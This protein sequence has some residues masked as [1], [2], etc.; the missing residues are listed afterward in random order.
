M[1]P[2]FVLFPGIHMSEIAWEYVFDMN[3]IKAKK[4]DFITQ[5][6]KLGKV[7][8]FTPKFFNIWYYLQFPVD[9]E[10]WK[11]IYNKYKRFSSDID[12][13][14]ED[15]NYDIICK[16]IHTDVRNKYG[17]TVKLIPIGHSYGSE[18]ALLFSKMYKKECLFSVL[19][20]GTVHSLKLQK[21][22]YKEYDKKNEKMVKKYFNNNQNLHK[23]LNKI[24][25]SLET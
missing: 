14:L 10:K 21:Q 24:K 5:L 22:F 17:K 19:I 9:D 11:K 15:L 16:K 12:F 18:I 2:V 13:N 20:D 25:N 6:K 4:L 1:K 7:Y 23:I 8:L 3:S